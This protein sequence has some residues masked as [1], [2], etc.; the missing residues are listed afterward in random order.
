MELPTTQLPISYDGAILLKA[1][2]EVPN[3]AKI[4]LDKFAN[5]KVKELKLVTKA[6]RY[7]FP[8]YDPINNKKAFNKVFNIIDKTLQRKIPYLSMAKVKFIDILNPSSNTIIVRIGPFD[9]DTTVKK[10]EALERYMRYIIYLLRK[11]NLPILPSNREIVYL[12]PNRASRVG[13]WLTEEERNAHTF[14]VKEIHIKPAV[15][16]MDRGYFL[17]KYYDQIEKVF[18]TLHRLA[19]YAES[20]VRATG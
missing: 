18:V 11:H 16:S 14:N 15:I 6:F 4:A 2:T 1:K 17:L 12:E 5:N 10:R 3:L 7:T 9:A 19:H 20:T 13:H 8:F